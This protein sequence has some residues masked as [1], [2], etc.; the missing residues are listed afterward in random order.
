MAGW[1]AIKRKTQGDGRS[2]RRGPRRH[3]PRPLG[4]A[5]SLGNI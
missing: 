2:T 4:F 1:A 3:A 5:G